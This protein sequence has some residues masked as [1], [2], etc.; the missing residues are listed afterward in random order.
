MSH[1]KSVESQLIRISINTIKNIYILI[2]YYDANV[3]V[4]T[5]VLCTNLIFGI[6][7][8]VCTYRVSLHYRVIIGRIIA[9]QQ[10]KSIIII[11]AGIHKQKTVYVR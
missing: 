9:D 1:D 11:P 5:Y 3:H 7:K 8:N 2:L 10:H 6:A 4:Y